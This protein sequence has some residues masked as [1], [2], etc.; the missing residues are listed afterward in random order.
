MALDFPSSPTTN[1]VYSSGGSSWKY[2]GAAWTAL[3]SNMVSIVSK[4]ANY[5]VTSGDSGSHFDNLGASADI[6]LTLPTAAAGLHYSFTVL[7][8]HYIRVNG[9]ISQGGLTNTYIRSTTVGHYLALE[10]HDSS[11]W[12]VSSSVGAWSLGV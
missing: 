6:V 12:V 5:T 1:Q 10:A 11:G 9:T 8:A 7:A 3:S 2:N 4:T